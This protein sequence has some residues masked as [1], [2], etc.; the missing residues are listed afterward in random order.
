MTLPMGRRRRLE[1]PKRPAAPQGREG[2]PGKAP[3]PPAPRRRPAEPEVR[4]VAAVPRGARARAPSR[5][6]AAAAAPAPAVT[7]D[8]P[9]ARAA[10]GGVQQA[11]VAPRVR[12]DQ[13]HRRWHRGQGRFRRGHGRRWPHRRQRV[14]SMYD[15]GQSGLLRDNTAGGNDAAKARVEIDMGSDLPTG[16]TTRTI[17]FWAFVPRPRG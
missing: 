7:E 9:E 17:E 10:R 5:G 14:D 15:D 6:A 16:N 2:G 1:E 3:P 13:L 4:V 8:R 11:L 12:A